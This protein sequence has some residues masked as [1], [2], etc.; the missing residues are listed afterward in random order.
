MGLLSKSGKV[1][2]LFGTLSR[3]APHLGNPVTVGI[4]YPRLHFYPSALTDN[5]LTEGWS[6]RIDEY[7]SEHLHV[8]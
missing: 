2:L 5:A 1:V 6:V 4:G 3:T 7:V 8:K